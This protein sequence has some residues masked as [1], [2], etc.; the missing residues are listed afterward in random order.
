MAQQERKVESKP[1]N[2]DAAAAGFSPKSTAGTLRCGSLG[3]STQQNVRPLPASRTAGVFRRD[4]PQEFHEL[5]GVLEAREVDEFCHGGH[6]HGELHAAQRLEGF[7][8]R[9]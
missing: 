8:D 1:A 3:V 6:G 7:D 5:S 4:Q 9:V 2:Y